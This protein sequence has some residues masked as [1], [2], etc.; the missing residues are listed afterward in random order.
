V[1]VTDVHV[2]QSAHF[3]AGYAN[4]T[5]GVLAL[6]FFTHFPRAYA[7]GL[8]LEARGG[9]ERLHFM[10]HSWIVSLFLDCLPGI[11]GLRCPTEGEKGN[12]TDAVRRGFI[13][14]HA[15]SFNGEPELM[16]LG[17]FKAAINLTHTLDDRF[18]LPHKATMSQRDVP[19]MSRAVLSPLTQAGVRGITIGVNCY[20]MPA[21]APRAF[22]WLD[23]AT[24]ATLPT[25]LHPYNYGMTSY[26]DSVVVPGLSH[27]ATFAWRGDNAGPPDSVQEV[28]DDFAYIRT[29][30]PGANVF[31]STLDNFTQLLAAPS[32][33]AT[34][35][36]VT[37]EYGD[38]WLHGAAADPFK[39][40]MNARASA[41][42]VQCLGEGGGCTPGDP[43]IANFT[44][45]L[46][47]NNEHTYG[48]SHAWLNDQVTW[49][50]ADLQAALAQ[51]LP[52]FLD[53]VASWQEQRDW[54]LGFPL[55]ALAGHPLQ[56]ALAEAWGDLYPP[57]PPPS[58]GSAAGGG[59]GWAPLQPGA[60]PETV[61]QWT[62]AF[63]PQSG[64]L[65]LLAH[66]PPPPQP[67]QQAGA[68]G[69]GDPGRLV[70]VNT[71]Q[72]PLSVFFAAE[73][74]TYDNAS[75]NEWMALYNSANLPGWKSTPGCGFSDW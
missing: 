28:L 37:A 8:E 35:P 16:H 58:P 33:A 18:G 34:L 66:N 45:L 62:V 30:F 56:A 9:P 38:T 50:N 67:L 71:T 26:N 41:L 57:L 10:T 13:Y 6:W 48:K 42:L 73:Y 4:T 59:D 39:T 64:A 60:P 74:Q 70:W 52:N 24:G 15:F 36:T 31:A 27:A 29:Q 44:R 40:A 3:D 23:S 69:G 68:G 75:I 51:G 65:S 53:T 21:A 54:G 5:V 25:M 63:H 17:L 11:P 1:P 49:S 12:F 32:I 72:D 47:K 2:F 14:W 19:G 22:M 61:G 46:L 55:Q 7:I 43:A 20:S